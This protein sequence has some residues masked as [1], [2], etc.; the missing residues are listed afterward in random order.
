MNTL[1]VYDSLFGNTEQ[2]AVAMA[3]ALMPHGPSRSAH[4]NETPF[5]QLRDVDLLV[6]GCPTQQWN[7]MPDMKVWLQRAPVEAV[8]GARVA[9]FDTRPRI[10][11][12]IGRHAAPLMARYLR[13]RGV[14]LLVPHEGF[15]VRDRDRRLEQ[16][17]VE[18]AVAWATALGEVVVGQ[19]APRRATAEETS[20]EDGEAGGATVEGGETELPQDTW[21]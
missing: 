21:R 19:M 15:Y 13:R 2:L 7:L 17:E 12:W 1:I 6:L 10:P 8:R 5:T 9:C 18:R 4:V 11:L 14:T 20:A 16:G 3:R